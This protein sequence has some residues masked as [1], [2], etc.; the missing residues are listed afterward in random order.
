MADKEIIFG[1]ANQQSVFWSSVGID[2]LA[3]GNYRNVRSFNPDMFMEDEEDNTKRR[4]IWYFDGNSFGEYKK[5][6]LS[7][8][9]RRG[10]KDKFGPK[11]E[12]CK[13]L[14]ENNTP[15]NVVWKEPMSFKHYL[16]EIKNIVDEIKTIEK[17][18][19]I[20]F[21]IEKINKIKQHNEM[22]IQK[23]FNLGDKGFNEN[24][25]EAIL[26]ALVALKADRNIDLQQ[27]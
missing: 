21:C 27:L 3:T 14:L 9:F 22:L 5:A 12:Y 25:S 8:A 26:S 16:F 19:R 6:Q 24:V 17:S 23:G 18:V 10:L 7:L 1:Y 20:D 11:C 15:A 2:S 4:G 13:E